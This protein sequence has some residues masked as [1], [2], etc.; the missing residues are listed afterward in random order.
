MN[1]SLLGMPS[2]HFAGDTRIC[3]VL[4]A[5]DENLVGASDTDR[6]ASSVNLG[7]SRLRHLFRGEV[8]VSLTSFVRERRIA[9]SVE[10][11]MT[12]HKRIN[13]IASET[14]FRGLGYF[15]RCFRRRFGVSPTRFRRRHLP[16]CNEIVLRCQR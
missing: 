15:E 8:G 5:I 1:L 12:T 10:L 2:S 3:K 6:L 16:N 7:A 13:E 14:G 4:T 9:R 11:L